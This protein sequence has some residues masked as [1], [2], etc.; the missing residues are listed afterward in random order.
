MRHR[1]SINKLSKTPAHR[2][3]MIRN[4]LISFYR[5]EQIKTT[6]AKS[7]VLQ[8]RAERL[9]TRA[10]ED[11]VHNRRMVRKW[12]Q[13]KDMLNKLFTDIGPRY[14]TREGGYTRI[15]K[16]GP[17]YGDA[18]EMVYISLVEKTPLSTTPQTTSKKKGKQA[19]N[20]ESKEA[21][22]ET[23]QVSDTTTDTNEST[24]KKQDETPKDNTPDTTVHTDTKADISPNGEETPISEVK[25]ET[26]NPV[27][28]DNAPS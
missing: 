24:N 25:A 14:K 4:M 10:K 2:K 1:V 13:D 17:R 6:H 22:K 19:P 7:K 26:D 9:I 16:I 20:K 5:Y 11:T 12:V 21:D 8:R 18:S 28:Q 15:V 3:A 23:K 27:N